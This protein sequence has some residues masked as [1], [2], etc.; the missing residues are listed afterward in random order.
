MP[1]NCIACSRGG[2]SKHFFH[3]KGPNASWHCLFKTDLRMPMR[4]KPKRAL[5][6]TQRGFMCVGSAVVPLRLLDSRPSKNTTAV[7]PPSLPPRGGGRGGGDK[8]TSLLDKRPLL[9][10]T[11]PPL[12]SPRLDD[13]YITGS[14][15]LCTCTWTLFNFKNMLPISQL[16]VMF[17]AL[18]T[19]TRIYNRCSHLIASLTPYRQ[20][21]WWDRIVPRLLMRGTL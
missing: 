9:H 21:T 17:P 8:K 5:R 6:L 13:Y 18:T 7:Q 10:T 19:H 3:K 20:S 14:V 15:T 4:E 11:P 12:Y 2:P 1:L 16:L